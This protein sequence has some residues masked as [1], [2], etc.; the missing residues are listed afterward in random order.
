MVGR[1]WTSLEVLAGES[2]GCLKE[3][4]VGRGIR[5]DSAVA[6]EMWNVIGN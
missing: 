2:Q 6:S 3:T 1:G 5:S 4:M